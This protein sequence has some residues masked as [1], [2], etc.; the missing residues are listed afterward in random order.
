MRRDVSTHDP[1]CRS[2]TYRCPN[3]L[4]SAFRFIAT[5]RLLRCLPT[6]TILRATLGNQTSPTRS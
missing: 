5:P 4:L 1:T 2:P 6:I 3:F